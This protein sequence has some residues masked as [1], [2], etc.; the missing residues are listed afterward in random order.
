MS[1]LS[2]LLARP[3]RAVVAL[4]FVVLLVAAAGLGTVAMA[5]RQADGA[6]VEA[7]DVSVRLNDEFDPPDTNGT[8]EDCFA[9]G[10]PGDSVGVYGDVTVEVPVSW[11][12]GD[13][14]E[15]TVAV[16]LPATD[17]TTEN[18]VDADGT[19]TVEVFAVFDDD[20][21]LAVGEETTLAVEVFA[22]G[23]RVAAATRTVTVEEGTR[24]YDC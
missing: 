5:D 15:L 11:R 24:T 2:W 16:S 8:V 7:T 20:E 13:S 19:E 3:A 21:T 18:T 9:S 23:E 6:S 1:F 22:D 17:A 12:Y 14:T 10:T 4:G